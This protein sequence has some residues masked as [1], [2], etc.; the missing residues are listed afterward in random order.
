MT[1]AS[2]H[3]TAGF[4][5]LTDCAPLVIAHEQGFA[6][7]EGISL[8]LVR[9]TSWATIRDRLAVGHLD[10]AHALAP[11]PIASNLDLG[12][13]PSK[14][15]AP[16]A[17]GFGG[18]TITV[19]VDIFNQ[20]QSLGTFSNLDAVASLQAM[21]RLMESR[22][23]TGKPKLSFGI[24]HPYSAHHYELAYWLAAGKVSPTVDV[25]LIVLP[26]SLM[27]DALSSGRIDGFCAGEPWGSIAVAQNVGRIITTK[28]HIW[29][30]SPEKVLA[31]RH[32]WADNNRPALYCL[33]RAIYR[34]CLWCDSIENHEALAEIL[35]RHGYLNRPVSAILPGLRRTLTTPDGTPQVVDGFLNFSQRAATFPWVS[36][37]LWLYTQMLRWGQV[38]PSVEGQQIARDT[39]RPDIYRTALAPLAVA[40]PGANAKVEGALTSEVPVGTTVGRL[41]LGPDG[42]FDGMVFDPDKVGAYIAA[43]SAWDADIVRRD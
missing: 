7:E 16:M 14:L 13:L 12:P 1:N 20:L 11:M 34:A 36:H 6:E 5:P 2:Q 32:E 15:I 37:A 23:A 28:A 39:F 38:K 9:E 3:V 33:L 17:L 21:S 24:V 27:A 41:S 40:M 31:V 30:S 25:E 18:N 42:F 22:R 35:S 19:S 43:L 29:R 4:I 26:P 8:T 10:V